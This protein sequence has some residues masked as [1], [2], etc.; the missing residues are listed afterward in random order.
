[1]GFIEVL[2]IVIVGLL[3]LFI[4]YL[5]G[6]Y[7]K[8]YF[9]KTR[10]ETKYETLDK[11]IINI[12]NITEKVIVEVKELYGEEKVQDVKLITRALQGETDHNSRMHKVIGLIKFLDFAID[13]I[14]NNKN[15]KEYEEELISSKEKIKYATE[16]YNN[17]VNDYEEYKNKKLASYIAKIFKFKDY[18][19]CN[20]I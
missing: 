1:M 7:N 18:N 9:Y 20:I 11:E 17:C 14:K 16:F 6:I 10:V 8:L 12:T 15:L 2:I 19:K 4:F 3:L 5:L 13:N